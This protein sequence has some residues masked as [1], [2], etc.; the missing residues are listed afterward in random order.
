M[1]ITPK[2]S[3][4]DQSTLPQSPLKSPKIREERVRKSSTN[5]RHRKLSNTN[6]NRDSTV[7]HSRSYSAAEDG[8]DEG[9]D[10]LLSAYESEESSLLT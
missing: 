8:D 7:R 4:F 1:A 10:D 6:S 9:Y 5:S 2:A 3:T